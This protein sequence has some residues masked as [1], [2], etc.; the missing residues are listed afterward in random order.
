M[1][2]ALIFAVSLTRKGGGSAQRSAFRAHPAASRAAVLKA[3]TAPS[4]RALLKQPSGSKAS[5]C[6]S[7]ELRARACEGR[8]RPRDAHRAPEAA[9]ALREAGGFGG[10]GSTHLLTAWAGSF[11]VESRESFPAGMLP[12]PRVLR[13]LGPAVV[14]GLRAFWTQ[15]SPSG[16]AAPASPPQHALAAMLRAR[17]LRHRGSS[18]SGRRSAHRALECQYWR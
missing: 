10:S 18:R 15:R 3:V 14:E 8:S 4:A 2:V 6:A 17:L 13:A 7:S 16:P 12:A 9:R 1:Q 11:G 5:S